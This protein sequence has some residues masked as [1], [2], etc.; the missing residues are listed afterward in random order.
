[1]AISKINPC[2]CGNTMCGVSHRTISGTTYYA[3]SCLICEEEGT[4]KENKEDAI[5]AWNKENPA[6][7]NRGKGYHYLTYGFDI[8]QTQDQIKAADKRQPPYTIII[9]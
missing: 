9:V 8:S 7:T 5:E 3:V 6:I 4:V 1:M 2:K